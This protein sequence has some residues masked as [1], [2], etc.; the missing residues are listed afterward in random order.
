MNRLQPPPKLI[1]LTMGNCANREL[2]IIL[3]KTLLQAINELL[4]TS[5]TIIEITK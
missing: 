4:Q 1:C 3:E 5:T 2:K